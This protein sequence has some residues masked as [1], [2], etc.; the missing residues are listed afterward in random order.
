MVIVI[1]RGERQKVVADK[2]IILCVDR[3]PLLGVI[4]LDLPISPL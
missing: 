4:L 2:L 1:K 3:L